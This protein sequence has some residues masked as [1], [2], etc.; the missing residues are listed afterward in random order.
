MTRSTS[1]RYAGNCPQNTKNRTGAIKH[2]FGQF[3]DAVNGFFDCLALH[4]TL[5]LTR[6][7]H[8]LSVQ[9][10]TDHQLADIGLRRTDIN[11]EYEKSHH[12]HIHLKN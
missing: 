5:R 8:L 11:T 3:L 1:I 2:G 7:S 10:M 9:D 6:R 4:L 12:W